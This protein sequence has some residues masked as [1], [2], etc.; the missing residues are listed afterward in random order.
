MYIDSSMVKTFKYNGTKYKRITV[1]HDDMN[2]PSKIEACFG[3]IVFG[4]TFIL[5]K[6]NSNIIINHVKERGLYRQ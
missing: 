5:T 1:Q 6:E 3:N 4:E 2:R